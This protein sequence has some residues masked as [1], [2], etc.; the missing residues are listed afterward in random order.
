MPFF[1]GLSG[2]LL[3]LTIVVVMLAEVAIFMPSVARFR[4]DYLAERLRRAE[5]AALTVM[6]APEGIVPA[7]LQRQLLER[8][9]ALSVSVEGMGKR[10]VVL[11]APGVPPAGETFD[12]RDASAGELIVDTLARLAGTDEDAL[13]RIVGDFEGSDY[14]TIDIVVPSA[15]LRDAMLAYG[16][17]ILQLSLVISIV[18]AA[19][20]FLTVR[21]IVV[22]PILRLSRAVRRFQADP[23]NPHSIIRPR[24]GPDEIAEA[25]AAIAGMQREVQQSLS[26]RARLAA[27]GQAV[28]KVSHDLRNM[29]SAGQMVTERLEVSTDP[30]VARVL[31]KLVASLDRAINLCQR[32]LAY[33]RAEEAPPV[34]RRVSLRRLAEEVIE[35]Q[36][37]NAEE[38]GLVR[39]R[40]K[41]P[42]GRTVHADPEQLYRV[43]SNLV[44]NAAD[45][46]RTTGRP[47]EIAVEADSSEATDTIRI[48]DTGP[49]MPS[50]AVE[51]LFQPFR[52]SARSDGVGL[53]L[54]ISREL[55]QAHGGRLE[56]V[57]STTEGTEFA[58]TLPRGDALRADGDRQSVRARRRPR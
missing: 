9:E 37:L 8:S 52:G 46:I 14:M 44:R 18:T 42:E 15:P 26:E 41:I 25:E 22:T 35:A 6:A 28:A 3:I 38:G 53:G 1:R 21:R 17:R 58:I 32:T 2:R 33:G 10:T 16:W 27:L 49:G 34:L 30:L 13:I 20:V 29:L 4:L 48:R 12:L 5:I 55:I 57:I 47:G 51:H 36:G 19:V 40:V 7:D 45:A 56:L 43:L 31:P 23:E 39:C 50:R 54:S 11:S 24:G